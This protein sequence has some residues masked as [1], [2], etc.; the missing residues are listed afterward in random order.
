MSSLA[1][2]RNSVLRGTW[3]IAVIA[4]IIMILRV[5]A[6]V[7][8]H[9][10]G[11]DDATMILALVSTDRKQPRPSTRCSSRRKTSAGL[12]PSDTSQLFAL[13]ASIFF[14]IAVNVYGFS[15]DPAVQTPSRAANALKNYVVVQVLSVAS[16]CVGRVAFILYLIPI[17]S[18]RKIY[19]RS[20]WVLLAL[21]VIVNVLTIILILS[22][23]R[24]IR[25]VWDA[26]IAS[27]TEC[28]DGSVQLYY[29]YFQIGKWNKNEIPHQHKER[30]REKKLTQTHTACNSSTDLILSVFPSIIFWNLRLRLRIKISL[31]ILTSL[32]LM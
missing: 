31:V 13:I 32:G 22:Q 14:T 28:M 5:F 3:A 7:K 17:L 16:T 18:T 21:Q 29:G 12:T 23:C 30:E 15:E 26:E 6:K 2:D 4:I 20:L 10:V 27:S 25:G 1:G 24:D 9:H 19:K 8:L 11:V